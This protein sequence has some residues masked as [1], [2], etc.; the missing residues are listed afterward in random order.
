MDIAQVHIFQIDDFG[1]IKWIKRKYFIQI[2]LVV[3][4]QPGNLGGVEPLHWETEMR[5]R[6]GGG[7]APMR[8]KVFRWQNIFCRLQTR[9][10]FAEP[11][12]LSS[13][14]FRSK[15]AN[16]GQRNFSSRSK[17]AWVPLGCATGQQQRSKSATKKTSFGKSAEF[18]M[19]APRRDK[20][21]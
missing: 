11:L 16:F 5:G 2:L 17:C 19:L 8:R 4:S 18:N 14:E 9:T 13:E 7:Y 20:A 10:S 3:T 21:V 15:T 12:A 1:C 6:G